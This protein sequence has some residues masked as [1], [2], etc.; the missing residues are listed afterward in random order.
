MNWIDLHD[1][2][3]TTIPQL[4]IKPDPIILNKYD[5]KIHKILDEAKRV[6]ILPARGN[7]KLYNQ[8]ELYVDLMTKNRDI[9]I[10]RVEDIEKFI[11][12]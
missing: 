6:Y 4:N 9:K 1:D 5:W 11:I 7:D 8:L 3:P 10:I 12:A 2:F